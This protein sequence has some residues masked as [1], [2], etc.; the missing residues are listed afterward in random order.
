MNCSFSRVR[1]SFGN[2]DSSDIAR[3]PATAAF[4]SPCE[5]SKPPSPWP[6]NQAG[7]P[8]QTRTGDPMIKSWVQSLTR[9][10]QDAKLRAISAISEGPISLLM[11]LSEVF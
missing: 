7:A 5:V 6:R 2:W 4:A 1:Y 11:R 10:Y 9:T 3:P 8:S